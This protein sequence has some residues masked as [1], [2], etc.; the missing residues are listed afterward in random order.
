MGEAVS[1]SLLLID[2]LII[3]LVADLGHP[4]YQKREAA[5]AA[6]RSVAPMAAPKLEQARGHPDPEV[7][8]RADRLLSEYYAARA[9]F[10]AP[11]LLPT[12][13]PC[14]P[15]LDMLPSDYPAREMLIR[16]YLEQARMADPSASTAGWSNYRRATFLFIRDQLAQGRSPREVVLVLDQMV[17]QEQAWIDRNKHNPNLAASL[18]AGK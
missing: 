12:C 3:G 13:Y 4:K 8:F 2:S 15:W 14:L 11:R 1:V 6:I 9:D 16:S 5:A 17:L 10:L 18:P 7:A